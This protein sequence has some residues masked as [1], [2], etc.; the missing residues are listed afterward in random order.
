M[1]LDLTG[2]RAHFA[3][4][5]G[6]LAVCAGAVAAHS[7]VLLI[8]AVTGATIAALVLANLTLGIVILTLAS[9]TG[10]IQLG[11]AATAPKAVGFLV[12]VSWVA[13][14]ATSRHRFRRD[15][16]ADHGGLLTW[17]FLFLI[18]NVLSAAWAHSPSTAL[19]GASRYAQDI[20]LL[21]IV[22]TGVRSP[23]HAR[24]VLS[25]LVAGAL[26]CVLYG[27]IAGAPA[28][29]DGRN[30]GTFDDPN[31]T[32]MV[33]VA[34]T[35]LALALAA[36]AARGSFSRAVFL[37]AAI[38]SLGGLVATGSRGGFVGLA[39][40]ALCG[41][42]IAG[43]WRGRALG[44][45]L[46]CAAVG[47]IWF[48]ALAPAATR[49]HLTSTD[50]SGRS[51]L[52]LVAGRAIEAHPVA[53]LGTDNF[54]LQSS[55]YLVAPG[56]TTG[57]SHI[58]TR[59]QV[60]HNIYLEIWSDAG[61]IGLGLFLGLL[62][63]ALRC[64]Y[65]AIVRLRRAGR[66]ADELLARG[67]VAAIVGVLASDFFISDMYGKQLWLMM[68]LAVALLACAREAPPGLDAQPAAVN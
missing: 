47:G 38:G 28:G 41:V 14:L 7:P 63:A 62:G 66:Q 26:L 18:W 4:L 27:A 22:Y 43:R 10:N 15:L 61:V 65:L 32:A 2:A 1:T 58:I 13:T 12:I 30:F 64:G 40:M 51:T 42:A 33:L 37:L 60:A 49:Q 25:A 11:G 31:E 57:A 56:V 52:W 50:S 54:Q 6:V 34:A 19:S 35:G 8:A 46:V 21:P 20:A 53:G 5:A 44:A 24:W 23:R 29:S 67:V 3:L 17:A 45:V 36:A 16:L 9:F 68:A 59:P 39:A 55:N 48:L